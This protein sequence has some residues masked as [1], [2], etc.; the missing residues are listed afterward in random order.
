MVP[1]HWVTEVFYLIPDPKDGKD[2]VNKV[3][4][5]NILDQSAGTIFMIMCMIGLILRGMEETP[6]MMYAVN[7]QPRNRRENSKHNTR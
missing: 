1:E 2:Y 5:V 7:C 4:N 3:K 6:H